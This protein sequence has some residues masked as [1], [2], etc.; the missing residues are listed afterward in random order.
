MLL[1]VNGVV[2]IATLFSGIGSP[3]QGA[4]RVYGDALEN[5][6]DEKYYLSQKAIEG[7]TVHAQRHTERGNG[8][9]FHPTVGGG[10][11]RCA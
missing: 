11:L 10:V 7:F 1:A 2:R 8:F 6:V 3:E 9:K 4:K 5:D